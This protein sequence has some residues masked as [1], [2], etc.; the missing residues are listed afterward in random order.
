MGG[1]PRVRLKRL[2]LI[3]DDRHGSALLAR[4]LAGQGYE[5]ETADSG[6]LGLAKA[7]NNDYELLVIDLLLGDLMGTEVVR[8]LQGHGRS[9]PFALITGFASTAETVEAMRLGAI[10]VLEKPIDVGALVF[11]AERAVVF[12]QTPRPHPIERSSPVDR[13]VQYALRACRSISDTKT[14]QQ[15]AKSAGVS[16]SA[17]CECCRLV[18]LQPIDA[19]DFVRVLRALSLWSAHG[20]WRPEV[21]FDISDRRTL[22]ALLV[23]A[24]LDT[25]QR[26]T[27]VTIDAFIRNQ[28]FLRLDSEAL[29]AL[30]QSLKGHFP[31]V[32][33]LP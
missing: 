23:R 11:I 27:T 14:I 13:W 21:Y 33:T 30:R 9:T 12:R 25:E 26:R 20:C 24:G 1:T 28:R 15:W 6:R 31:S 19:R 16:C 29:T 10:D 8:R 7:I 3:D 5:V 22:R 2:L 4:L 32:W 18:D 17:L